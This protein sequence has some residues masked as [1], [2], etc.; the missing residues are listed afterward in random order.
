MTRTRNTELTLD[1]KN[2][3]S[4][5]AQTITGKTP[6]ENTKTPIIIIIIIF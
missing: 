3:K 2:Y 4:Y 5:T 6:E 1:R